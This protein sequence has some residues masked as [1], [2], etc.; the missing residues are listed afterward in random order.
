[1]MASNGNH[2][3]GLGSG[4][5]I[6]NDRNK[7]DYAFVFKQSIYVWPKITGFPNIFIK[8]GFECLCIAGG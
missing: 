3:M 2:L 1:M 4:F 5:Y 7:R 6:N 8:E